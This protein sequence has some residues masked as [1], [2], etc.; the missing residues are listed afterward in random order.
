MKLWRLAQTKHQA[1]DGHGALQYGGRYCSPGH[2][3]VSFASE[4]GLAVLVAMRYWQA[5]HLADAAEYL[6][7]WTHATSIPERVPSELNEEDKKRYVDDWSASRR[8]LLVAIQSAVLPEADVILMNTR[9]AGASSVAPLVARPF[10]FEEC[11]HHPPMFEQFSG[12]QV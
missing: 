10:S 2:P 11:L 1:L 5:T 6:L 12:R 9:H 7:G 3:L 4:A 8:S